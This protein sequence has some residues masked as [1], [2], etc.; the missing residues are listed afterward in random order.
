MKKDRD[1]YTTTCINDFEVDFCRTIAMRLQNAFKLSCLAA[2]IALAGCEAKLNL[3][4]VEQERKKEILRTDLY[5]EMVKQ[6]D[7]IT[8]VGSQGVILTS[9]NNGKSWDR[10]ILEGKPNLIGLTLCPDNTLVAL[11]FDKSLWTSQDQG[12]SW[13]KNTI[14]T[15]ESVLDISCAPDGTYWVTGSFSTLLQSRDRGKTWQED[16]F[17]EDT[18]LTHIRFFDE[19]TGIIS[20]EFGV[21]YRT[22]NGGKNWQ[23]ISTIGDSFYPLTTFFSDSLTGWAGGLNGKIHHTKDGGINWIEQPTPVTSPIYAFI[24]SDKHLIATGDHGTVLAWKNDQ[25]TRVK[26][27]GT[28]VYLSTGSV[29]EKTPEAHE[30]LVAGGWGTLFSIALSEE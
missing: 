20:G 18:Q 22:E 29:L 19:N 10:Q 13:Q 27:P 9:H 4:G 26:S 6:K 12:S 14:P 8:L 17:G 30:L 11:A 2:C 24:Q 7:L 21:F 23:L 15:Q 28:P 16:T 1:Q 25:W 3:Q 5:Q